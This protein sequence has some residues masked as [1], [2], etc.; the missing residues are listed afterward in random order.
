MTETEVGE[1]RSN[2]QGEQSAPNGTSTLS[3][4]K[5][6]SQENDSSTHR[7]KRFILD[8]EERPDGSLSCCNLIPINEGKQPEP[9]VERQQDPVSTSTNPNPEYISGT[10]PRKCKTN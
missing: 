10:S 6:I 4:E 7:R 9:A 3:G 8:C 2:V 5:K 1:P